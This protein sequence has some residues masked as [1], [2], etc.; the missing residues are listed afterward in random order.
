MWTSGGR[1]GVR[2]LRASE[3]CERRVRGG[4]SSEEVVEEEEE[5][6]DEEEEEEEED[7]ELVPVLSVMLRAVWE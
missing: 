2:L 4:S 6:D 3:S 1:S 5:E 7:E